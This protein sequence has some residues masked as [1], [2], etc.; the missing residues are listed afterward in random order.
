MPKI[1]APTKDA[2][3]GSFRLNENNFCLAPLFIL[4]NRSQRTLGNVQVHF[5]VK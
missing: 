5:N 3:D 2:M 4:F 1:R